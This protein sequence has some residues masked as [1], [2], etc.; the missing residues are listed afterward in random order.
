MHASA[1]PQ[2][3][4]AEALAALSGISDL[5]R[6]H[7]TDEA[8]RACLV[9]VGL[10]RASGIEGPLLQDVHYTALVWSVAAPPPRTSS[11]QRSAA[12]TSNCAGGAMPPA[13][14]HAGARLHH[15]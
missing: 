11:Q 6:G 14:R 12:T 15:L 13:G 8:Q 10:A 7:P 1:R 9:A 4:L 2:S 5:A 3:S